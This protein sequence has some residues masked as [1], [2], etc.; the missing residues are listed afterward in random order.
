MAKRKAS[1]RTGK[2]PAATN[3]PADLPQADPKKKPFTP[4]L[5]YLQARGRVRDAECRG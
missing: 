3:V 4:T 1:G 2:T 5:G